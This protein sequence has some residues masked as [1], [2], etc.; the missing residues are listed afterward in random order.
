MK[1]AQDIRDA[2]LAGIAAVKNQEV[3]LEDHEGFQVAGL[4]SLDR[5]SILMEVENR[6]GLDFGDAN[7]E[8]FPNIGAYIEYIQQTWPDA[9]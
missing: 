7:P 5:M 9:A 3:R 6:L 2:V 4:D 8:K 1:S